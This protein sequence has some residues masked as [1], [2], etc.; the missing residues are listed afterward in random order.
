MLG[1]IVRVGGLTAEHAARAEHFLEFRI[2]RI[3][4]PLRLLL[5]IEVIK[6]AEV[7]VEAVDRR[8]ILV[9]VTQVILTELTCRVAL[10]FEELGHGYVAVLE[11]NRGA[12]HAD[13]G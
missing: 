6:I 10:S 12:G 1:R 8:E 5:G 11:P 9:Q 2:L 3:R 13:L 7:L 4:P